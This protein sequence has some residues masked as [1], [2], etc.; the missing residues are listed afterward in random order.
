MADELGQVKALVVQ[1]IKVFPIAPVR[2]EKEKIIIIVYSH[3][4]ALRS[5]FAVYLVA[6]V[7]RVFPI[8]R[9]DEL[10]GAFLFLRGFDRLLMGHTDYDAHFLVVDWNIEEK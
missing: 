4:P 7:F 3:G 9:F 10:L 1:S 8:Q 6:D 5:R 2:F